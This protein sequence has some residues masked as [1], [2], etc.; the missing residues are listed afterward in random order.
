[1]KFVALFAVTSAALFA[2][3][4]VD[5]RQDFDASA[6]LGLSIDTF[7]AQTTR[8]VL[9]QNPEDNGAQRERVIG[10]FNFA[11]RIAGNA[12]N[13][14][15]PQLWIYGQALHGARS[16]E[17]TLTSPSPGKQLVHLLRNA[18]S[19]EAQLGLRAELLSINVGRPDPARVYLKLQAGFLSIAQ[20]GGDVFDVHRIALGVLAIGGRYEGSYMEAGYG[21]NDVFRLNRYRRV[22]VTGHLTWGSE[23]W[24]KRG[25]RPFVSIFVDGDAST[26]ADSVQTSIGMNFDIDKIF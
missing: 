19:L 13:P 11:Y 21:R 23:H 9:Y 17:V 7:S 22:M 14:H 8:D 5:L 12:W 1:V 18:S 6:Y 24:R 10:G 4:T 15:S 20:G 26:G 3:E 16:A 2:Q 25:L